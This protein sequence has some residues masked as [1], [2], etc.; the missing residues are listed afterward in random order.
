MPVGYY[1]YLVH[2]KT[3]SMIWIDSANLL[4][5]IKNLSDLCCQ[6]EM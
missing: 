2:A 6:N 4:G 5:K 1:L 3:M